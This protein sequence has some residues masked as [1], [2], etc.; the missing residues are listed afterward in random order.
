MK[1]AGKIFLILFTLII[2]LIGI[3]T[4]SNIGLPK[5]STI[6]ERLGH[7][8]KSYL[9][10]MLHLRRKLGSEVIPGWSSSC[11]PL[12]VYNE[13]FAFLT[14]YEGVPPRGWMK[15]PQN[16]KAGHTWEKVPGDT[17]NGAPY[18]R[19]PLDEAS[20]EPQNFTVKI[21]GHWVPSLYTYEYAKVS[22]F[23]GFREDIPGFLKPVVPYRLLWH[24]IMGKKETYIEALAHEAFHA[25]QG[26]HAPEKLA[27]AEHAI[28]QSGDYPWHADKS[29]SLWQKE[30]NA[31][32]K[33]VKAESKEETKKYATVFLEQRNQRR[34]V[35]DL[36]QEE[37]E[38]EQRREWL[39][40]MAKYAELRLGYTA[41]Q[42]DTYQAVPAMDT[43][44]G[45]HGYAKEDAHW[46]QQLKELKRVGNKLGDGL[47][48]Y[49]GLAQARLL[50]KLSPGWQSQLWKK[51]IMLETML[52][53]KVKTKK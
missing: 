19:T 15:V 3:S 16:R 34:A 30:V 8:Q 2:V 43:I 31:L 12:V 10:E 48:Y 45:F 21:G 7:A 6:K 39:E 40:G 41:Y 17:F 52:K 38:Y 49:T 28:A 4:L 5:E 33:A 26:Q 1:L 25:F 20:G 18:Y 29:L 47:F 46:E 53:Q 42:H 27:A 37:V 50:D 14:G 24:V 44:R 32:Y 22:F 9:Q 36:Q 13:E 51:G 23:N 35:Q 11:T